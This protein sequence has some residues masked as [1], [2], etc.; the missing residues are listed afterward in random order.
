LKPF[1]IVATFRKPHV[2]QRDRVEVVVGQGYESESEPTEGDDLFDDHFGCTLA[3]LLTVRAPNRAKGAM[4]G[5][6]THCLYGGPHIS[7]ARYQIPTG[8]LELV[9]CDP[10]RFVKLPGSSIRAIG[11]DRCPYDVSVALDDTAG[12]P[13]TKGFFRI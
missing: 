5:T 9:R 10:S 11:E 2:L 12:F 13:D 8:G 6:P 4:L 7:I 1:R 3:G